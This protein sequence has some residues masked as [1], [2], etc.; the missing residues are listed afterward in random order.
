MKD[1]MDARAVLLSAIVAL[2]LSGHSAAAATLDQ[3]LRHVD[4]LRAG[5]DTPFDQVEARCNEL[6][7]EYTKP[8]EQAKIYFILA[9]VEG[10]SG[11]Q[12]PE[13]LIEYV[14]KALALPLEPLKEVPLYIY[15]G[16]AA[17]AAGRRVR[18]QDMAATRRQAAIPYL[19]G[20]KKN[21]H[22]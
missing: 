4:L 15:W 20:L 9:Q 19:Q 14:K 8:E 2:V 11:M 12:R 5:F 1:K 13:K 22:V 6:L 10:Q 17:H 21:P 7:E 18:R 3:Q 16:A